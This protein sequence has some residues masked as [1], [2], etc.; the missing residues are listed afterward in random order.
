MEFLEEP[1]LPAHIEA[2][3]DQLTEGTRQAITTLWEKYEAG[4]Y[5]PATSA[6][7]ESGLEILT[8]CDILVD[9]P[10]DGLTN[11]IYDLEV[12]NFGAKDRIGNNFMGHAVYSKCV[13]FRGEM[14]FAKTALNTAFAL[15][16]DSARESVM[17]RGSEVKFPNEGLVSGLSYEEFSARVEIVEWAIYLKESRDK[18]GEFDSHD[19]E[20]SLTL[21]TQMPKITS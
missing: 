3:L 19:E 12:R 6:V 1:P 9:Q 11:E 15:M 21:Q 4:D 7:P 8:G 16:K 20:P 13:A 17:K 10:R 18:E 5:P 14:R 2:L